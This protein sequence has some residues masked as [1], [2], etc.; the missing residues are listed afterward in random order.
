MAAPT[1]LSQLENDLWYVKRHPFLTLTKED[2]VEHDDC[3]VYVGSPTLDWMRSEED[4]YIAVTLVKDGYTYHADTEADG[5]YN[6]DTNENVS[7]DHAAYFDWYKYGDLNNEDTGFNIYGYVN[8][9]YDKL[10]D[11]TYE[12]FS[13][14]LESITLADI[15]T[16]TVEVC[17]MQ[18]K[19]VPIGYLDTTEVEEAI[20]EVIEAA[21]RL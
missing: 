1:K 17:R 2:F 20:D 6:F 18:H 10:N 21:R 9:I 14:W 8:D 13:L 12:G 3:I 15:E 16:I 19:K 11:T 5:L 4:I 7:G